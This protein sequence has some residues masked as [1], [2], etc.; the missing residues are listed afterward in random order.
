MALPKVE[1][2]AEIRGYFYGVAVSPDGGAIF[3]TDPANNALIFADAR[4]LETSA[5]VPVG[6]RPTFVAYLGNAKK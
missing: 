4:T 1:R 3:A 2:T 6:Q 5:T